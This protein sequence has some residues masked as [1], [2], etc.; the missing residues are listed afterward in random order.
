MLHLCQK[1][2]ISVKAYYDTYYDSFWYVPSTINEKDSDV[3]CCHL[4]VLHFNYSSLILR[5]SMG[6]YFELQLI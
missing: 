5:T 4:A 2:A 6:L 1:G 3:D